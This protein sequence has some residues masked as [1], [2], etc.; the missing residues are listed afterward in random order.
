[1]LLWRIYVARNYKT[2]LGLHGKCP[3]FVSSDCNQ[4]WSFT[5]HFHM[6]AIS[7]FTEIC[8]VGTELIHADRLTDRRIGRQTGRQTDRQTD[9]WTDRHDEANRRFSRLNEGQASKHNHH[10]AGK[11]VS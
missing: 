5:A 3:I 1:M 8:P 9:G 10:H 6:S 4:I 7:N 2:Y 11:E